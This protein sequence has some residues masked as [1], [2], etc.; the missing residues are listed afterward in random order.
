MRLDFTG[1][2]ESRGRG[3]HPQNSSASVK[4]RL[5]RS[6]VR[7]YRKTVVRRWHVRGALT[8]KLGGRSLRLTSESVHRL[9]IGCWCCLLFSSRSKGLLDNAR[10]LLEPGG[11]AGRWAQRNIGPPWAKRAT[12]PPRGSGTT[13]CGVAPRVAGRWEIATMLLSG[14]FP[15]GTRDLAG[16]NLK[17]RPDWRGTCFAP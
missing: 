9:L 2:I 16:L 17:P 1:T 8:I 10:A 6:L 5:I 14:T 13:G 4:S 15:L 11:T 7:L 3:G 12:W